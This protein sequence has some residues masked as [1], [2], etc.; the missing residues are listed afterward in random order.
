MVFCFRRKDV[1]QPDYPPFLSHSASRAAPG[2]MG[3][4]SSLA[5]VARAMALSMATM[6]GTSDTSPML[7]T[8]RPSAAGHSGLDDGNL[9]GWLNGMAFTFIR[10]DPDNETV[11][12]DATGVIIV[13]YLAIRP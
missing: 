3:R 7:Q 13:A 12:F 2:F 1:F 9:T 8:S 10:L 6:G 5:P 4:L 11:Q